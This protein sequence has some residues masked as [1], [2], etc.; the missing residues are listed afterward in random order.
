MLLSFCGVASSHISQWRIQDARVHLMCWRQ[1]LGR[2]WQRWGAYDG[3]LLSP[4]SLCRCL[5]FSVSHTLP[6]PSCAHNQLPCCLLHDVVLAAGCQRARQAPMH[7]C[8]PHAAHGNEPPPSSQVLAGPH[9]TPHRHLHRAAPPFLPH[10]FAGTVH[11]T[12]N[13]NNN[14]NNKKNPPHARDE[15]T[16]MRCSVPFWAVEKEKEGEAPASKR[17]F[18]LH[19]ATR[20]L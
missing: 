20:A 8:G 3:G 5:S 1:T 4:S 12:F 2:W 17:R 6:L 15:H 11:L 14:K 7:T 13:S 19:A 10:R 16:N 9:A 18:M